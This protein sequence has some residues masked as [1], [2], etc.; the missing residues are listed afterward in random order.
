MANLV[1]LPNLYT[2][3]NAI[4]KRWG[5]EGTQLRLDDAN[6]GSGQTIQ[7]TADAP[8]G[9]V[10]INVAPLEAPLL[11][12][13]VLQFDGGGVPQLVQVVLT[14]TGL[15]GATSLS[16]AP[17]AFDLPPLAYAS[18]SGVTL[19][20]AS[21]LI[22]A[23][24]IATGRVKSYC[25]GRYDDSQLATAWTVYNWAT[26]I[27]TKWV[28][29]RRGQGMTDA[30]AEEYKETMAELKDVRI[31]NLSIEDI[32]TRTSGWPFF[33]NVT[34][35]VRYDYNKIRVEPQMS[36][37]T[38]TVYPQFIDWNSAFLFQF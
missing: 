38:P 13:T 19:Y 35:D 33:S 31:G 37:G 11:P 12:G 15:V 3:P 2:N 4:F 21:L 27:A 23:A 5:V 14:S 10:T 20:L 7:V 18:D 26:I 28:A 24:S 30:L 6:N 25:C 32:G 36:E 22:E 17:L 29:E 34:V 16:V 9:S 1:T 8:A